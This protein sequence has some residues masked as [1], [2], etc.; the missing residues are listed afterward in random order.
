MSMERFK[1]FVN[2]GLIYGI[3]WD[4]F[5]NFQKNLVAKF[6]NSPGEFKNLATQFFLKIFKNPNSK[7]SAKFSSTSILKRVDS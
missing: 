6:W 2:N 5:L 7:L 1:F 3:Y 4:F